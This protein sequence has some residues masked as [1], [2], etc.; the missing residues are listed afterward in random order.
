LE[1]GFIGKSK[2][3]KFTEVL[4]IVGETIFLF[5]EGLSL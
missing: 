4:E 5:P 3:S 1:I 2:A